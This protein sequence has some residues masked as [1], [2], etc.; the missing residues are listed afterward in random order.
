[1]FHFQQQFPNIEETVMIRVT[2]YD[3][4]TG[5]K[6][7]LIEYNNIEAFLPISCVTKKKLRK[8]NIK[9][10]CKV[11]SQYPM[12]V[13]EADRERNHID[14]S[15]IE[16]LPDEQKQYWEFHQLNNKLENV[17]NRL[18]YI[19]GKTMDE[20]YTNI[21]HP[22][23]FKTQEVLENSD[24]HL[25]NLLK[26]RESVTELD[27]D[28]EYTEMLLK[29]HYTLFGSNP[30]KSSKTVTLISFD[31]DGRQVIMDLLAKYVNLHN[32]TYSKEDMYHDNNLFNVEIRALAIPQYE[33]VVTACSSDTATKQSCS[34]AQSLIEEFTKGSDFGEGVGMCAN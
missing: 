4:A 28:E 29:H 10:I 9:S 19:T 21:V 14:I 33:V 16:L 11:G 30:V 31:Q 15:N 23:L 5:F 8:K 18:H 20:L 27:L 6:V 34:I 25:I 26:L 17:I 3:E 1:M 12:S 24:L 32:N 13:I 7:Q 2:D 22:N